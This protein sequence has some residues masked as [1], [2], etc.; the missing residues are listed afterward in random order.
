[1]NIVIVGFFNLLLPGQVLYVPRHWWHY[2]ESVD[3]VTVSINSWIELEVDHVTRVSE[4]VAKVVVFALKGASSEDNVDD[5]LNPTEES[6]TSHDENMQYLNLALRA[7]QLGHRESTRGLG[8][9]RPVQHDSR[10][11]TRKRVHAAC[12]S[13]PFNVPYG[14]NLAPVRRVQQDLDIGSEA[15]PEHSGVLAGPPQ[16]IQA[17]PP[18]TQSGLCAHAGRPAG[19]SA[20]D[21]R[22]AAHRAVTTNDLLDCLA[23]PDIIA[24]VTE[25]LL[26]RH[27]GERWSTPFF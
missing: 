26:E 15:A 7:I 27:A 5:W 11:Q 6:V 24:R 14:P 20:E 1:M 23:H 18:L 19:N 17:S 9:H 3:P 12:E 4:A 25:L 16:K 22:E 21:C 13:N 8:D 2:V 10:G